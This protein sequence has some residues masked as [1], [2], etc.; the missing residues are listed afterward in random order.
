[1]SSKAMVRVSA[2]RWLSRL[3]AVSL[4]AAGAV[5]ATNGASP[6]FLPD[7]PIWV[8]D[9]RAID[10]G[11]VASR[12]DSDYFDFV[13][14]TFFSLGDRRDIHAVNTN[15]VDEVP[16]SSWFV[17]RI[18]RRS[19]SREEL[20]RGPDRV[21]S[22]SIAGWPVVAG[23]SEGLQAG[24]RVADPS[25]HLYQ[26]E[27]D[28]PSNPELAT[29]AEM[30]GTVFYHAFGYHVVDVYL[31]EIDPNEIVVSEK[32][33]MR[34]PVTRARRRM[35]R[36]DV[37]QVLAR[38]ARRPDGKYRALAS[39]FAD[40]S[41]LGSFRYYGT[42]SD[43][44]NDIFPHEH[45]RE[46]RGARVFAAWLNHDDSRSLNSL[47]MLEGES[48]KRSVRH[49]MF[50]FGSILGSGTARAQVARAGNEYILEWAPGFATLATMGLYLRP[51]MRIDYP[52]VPASVG[53]FESKAFDAAKWR[54]E[55]PN[56]AFDLMRPED[57]F[58]AARIVS[59]F[60]DDDIQAL[61]G[62]GGYSEPAATSYVTKA[63]IERRDKVLRLWLNQVNPV[64]D[65]ALSPAGRLSFA[66]A[67]VDARVATS[68]ESYSVRWF[69]FDNVSNTE[70]NVGE[71]LVGAGL[72]AQAPAALLAD[73]A[74]VG[75]SVTARHPEHPAWARPV[76][77]HFRRVGD[78]WS[79]VGLER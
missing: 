17:N 18:G 63:L 66:N 70:T 38:S 4:V 11:R 52:D 43:D 67:A 55:Y 31:V 23:K 59:R 46:L 53:R 1:M 10:A 68:P 50:D 7:D 56:V 76:T 61:V 73:S 39:R 35:T 47:D 78:A 28:P 51:W 79:L 9:D 75:V 45:R 65:L 42:R 6:R 8:D 36:K 77:A 3:A 57:A 27:F 58:W 29:G 5:A 60:S 24:Y 30:I 13:E 20:L 22:L 21:P 71:T 33:T 34:D 26:V 37:D 74:F 14:N 19:M 48:G 72:E 64:V 41:P 2:K 25:G 62:K 69:R 15:T 40:G 49:Y 54:P 12:E 16:D 32:A 44:P